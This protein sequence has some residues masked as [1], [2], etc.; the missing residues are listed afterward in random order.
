MLKSYS[1][2]GIAAI[3][4]VPSRVPLFAGLCAAPPAQ[5]KPSAFYM[6]HYKE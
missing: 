2:P 4:H 6:M 3:S 5:I 1:A